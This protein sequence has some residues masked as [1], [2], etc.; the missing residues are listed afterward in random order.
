M[1]TAKERLLATVAALVVFACILGLA[2]AVGAKSLYSFPGVLVPILLAVFVRA[3]I[4][5]FTKLSRSS[6]RGAA[7]Q[8]EKDTL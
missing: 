1:L 5:G 7:R 6:A 4:T 8:A 2:A 3:A